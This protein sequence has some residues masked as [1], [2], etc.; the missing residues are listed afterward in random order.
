MGSQL[1]PRLLQGTPMPHANGHSCAAMVK[2]AHLRA[3][4]IGEIA[5]SGDRG[6][7]IRY[8]QTDPAQN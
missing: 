5:E 3:N 1:V 6:P 8:N 2:I 4:L 7:R